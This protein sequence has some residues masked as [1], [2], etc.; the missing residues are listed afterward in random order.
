M[1]VFNW[2]VMG[3]ALA[4]T[5]SA[6]LELGLILFF[7]NQRIHCF[8][9]KSFILPQLKMLAA[10]FF[11][12]VFLYLPFRILDSMVFDTSKTIELLGLA[13]T[14]STIGLLVYIYFSALFEVKELT[15]FTNLI[16]SFGKWQKPLEKSIEMLVE[17]S[18]EGESI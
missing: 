6:L 7:L 17:T 14:T 18:V 2:G 5:L 10:S 13:V 1:F 16:T 12:A 8:G 4:T 3:L 9:K 15:F 11:M